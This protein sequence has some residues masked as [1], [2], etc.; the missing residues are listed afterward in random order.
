MRCMLCSAGAIRLLI[1]KLRLHWPEIMDWL[2]EVLAGDQ[3]NP[4][5][6]LI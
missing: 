3:A 6:V 2:K 5:I 1:E 4:L